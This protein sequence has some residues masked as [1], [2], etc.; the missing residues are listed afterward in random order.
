MKKFIEN[1]FY[2]KGFF[3][4]TPKIHS[5]GGFFE[6]FLWGLKIKY[7]VNKKLIL[8]VPFFDFFQHYKKKSR[9]FDYKIIL[10]IYSKL[11]FIEKLFSFFFT[12]W[13]NLNL[14]LIK[15]K[16]RGAFIKVFNIKN[17]DQIFFHTLGFSDDYNNFNIKNIHLVYK[18]KINDEILNMNNHHIKLDKNKKIVALCIKDSN[19][20]NVKRISSHACAEIKDYTNSIDHLIGKGFFVVRIGEPLMKDFKYSNPN[21]VDL[22]KVKNYYENFLYVLSQSNFY[23]GTSGSHSIIPELF[24]FKRKIVTNSLDFLYLNTSFSFENICIFK[25]IFDINL[26]KFL[27]YDEIYNNQE[28]LEWGDHN[29]KKYILI[30]NT[31]SEI[32]E[33]TK[34][35]L[36]REKI[37]FHHKK[38]LEEFKRMRLKCLNKFYFEKK[39]P[40]RLYECAKIN[41]L[42]TLLDDFLYP[43]KRLN[44]ISKKF[45]KSKLN[46]H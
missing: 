15:F 31:P 8:V 17:I 45:I 32:L 25:K 2:K 43:S 5:F 20:E 33:I 39:K 7:F 27:S 36:S 23:L 34:K 3:L 22:T 40:S 9:R 4:F 35:A 19:Y 18:N 46:N 12:F 24:N 38:N 30:D 41:I 13:L 37:S 44:E 21:Y 14:L 42:D 10:R 6:S 26:K 11:S 29:K 28:V 16:I 1:F